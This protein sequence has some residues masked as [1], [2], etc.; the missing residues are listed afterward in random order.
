MSNTTS[1]YPNDEWSLGINIIADICLN[2]P[3]G[4]TIVEFGSG[5]SSRCLVEMGYEVYSIEENEDFTNRH[6]GVNYIFAPIDPETGWYQ[7]EHVL[8][9]LPEDIHVLVIDGPASG[10]R[11]Q[12]VSLWG[13]ILERDG[14]LRRPALYIDDVQRQDGSTTVLGL[15][16]SSPWWLSFYEVSIISTGQLLV[17]SGEAPYEGLAA[18]FTPSDSRGSGQAILPSIANQKSYRDLVFA[19]EHTITRRTRQ[20]TSGY[21]IQ[22]VPSVSLENSGNDNA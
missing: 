3:P 5:E 8:P 20:G 1:T 21:S 9:Q 6:P 2:A 18:R 14:G 15:L 4:S 17:P 16:T 11:T 13:K 22:V 19:K 10:D 7:T 12:F